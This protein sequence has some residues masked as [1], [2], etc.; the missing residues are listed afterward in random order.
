MFMFSLSPLFTTVSK[1]GLPAASLSMLGAL[2]SSL[3]LSALPTSAAQAAS[4]YYN[5]A[6]STGCEK[7]DTRHITSNYTQTKYPIVM[8][9]GLLGWNRVFNTLD[10]FYG[11][12]QA[13]MRGGSDV[14]STKVSSINNS[15]VRGEQ[16]LKQVK[17]IAAISGSNKVN[18][19][20]HSQGG[21]DARYVAGVAPQYVAS[22]TAVSS[23]VQGSAMGDWAAKM[24]VEGSAAEGY[25]EGEYNT[26]SKIVFKLFDFVGGVLDVSSGIAIGDIQEQAAWQA[27]YGLSTPYSK[28]FNARFPDA[29]PS[30]YCGYPAATKVNGIEYYSFSGKGLTTN[31]L[32]ITDPVLLATSFSFK[33][34][35]NDGLVSVCSSRLGRVIRD[36]YHMNHLDSVNQLLGMVSLQETNP[37]SVYRSQ[38]NRLKNADL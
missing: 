20:G 24:I 18:L 22:V 31:L 14:Y 25:G 2:G 9:H 19:I 1:S 30:T 34:E 21:M 32:D 37:I 29:V 26:A 28:I 16:L 35:A 12:P 15:E 6:V 27:V 11:I 33:G 17:T 23:P 3:L 36:D 5:C 13:L 10:Y 8:A 4:S 7:V 38:V